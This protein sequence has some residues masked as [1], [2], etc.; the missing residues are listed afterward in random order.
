M[1]IPSYDYDGAIMAVPYSR[2]GDPETVNSSRMMSFT[3]P[4]R[5]A[6][7]FVVVA[8]GLF[9]YL[10][11][12][13]TSLAFDETSPEPTLPF[14]EEEQSFWAFQPI[15]NPDIPMVADETKAANSIDAFLL[16][17]LSKQGLGFSVLANKRQLLRRA[18]FDLLGLP[19]TP[20][21]IDRFVSD[22]SPQ[23]FERMIDRLLAS[24]HYGEKWGRQWLDLVRYAETAGFN[25]DPFRPMAYK[26]RDYVIRAFNNDTPYD[27][28]VQEQIAGDELFPNSTAALI[29]TGFNRMWPDESNASNVE[30][31]RQD[32]LNDL[33][34]N[35]GAAFLGLSIGCAQ[36]HDHK[37]DPILQEDFYQLQSFFAGIVLQD[38]V[39]IGTADELADYQRKLKLWMRQSESVR[40]ELHIIEQTARNQASLIKRLKFPK[41]VLDAI[42]TAPEKR[43]ALQHQ[44]AF[45]SVRQIEVNEKQ[46]ASKLSAEQKKRRAELKQQLAK[47]QKQRPKPPRFLDA[48]ATREVA[49]GP[50]KTHLLD[51]GSYNKPLHE[52]QPGYL[53]IIA[54]VNNLANIVP[55]REGTVGRRTTLAKW[56]TDPRNPLTARVMANRIWQG[57][58]G[59]GLVG[60]ANDLGI[61]TAP[62]RHPELL[63]WLASEFIARDWSIKSMHRLIMTSNAYRQSTFRVP[64]D[65]DLP[66]AAKIDPAN[67]LYWHYQRRRLSAESIRDAMLTIAGKL[68]PKMYGLGVK[69]QLP[70]KFSSREK[71]EVSKQESARNRRS[72][73]IHAKRNLPYPLL[74]VFDFPD[75]HES[76]AKRAQ[77]TVAPQA[78]MILNS[79]LVLKFAEA[80]A[81]RLLRESDSEDLGPLIQ[82]AYVATFSR[83]P[84]EQELTMATEFISQQQQLIATQKKDGKEVKP[85][86]GLPKSADPIKAMAIVDFCHVLLNA[87][88]FLYIE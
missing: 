20:D 51:G 69:P 39:P 71:W 38:R 55:P 44:L 75:M 82:R 46:L 31:A 27:R 66:K 23:A 77:T 41:I 60:N 50:P 76:C 37:F 54:G 58:F 74:K 59:S 43:T 79:D 3:S 80:L 12:K 47:L 88:E 8:V 7:A 4:I 57:H 9:V 36:C 40:D 87:N 86:N 68:N 22:D 70:P 83:M 30:L 52:L 5:V 63:D 15:Q 25:A 32:A 28:F 49:S 72:V 62:P 64:A 13:D 48:M 84:E 42:D 14:T 33:T 18:K 1:L 26:Y 85:I 67:E 34:A 65:G 16:W 17:E 78:L 53:K 6:R 10:T 35:V 21:E 61:Q 29:A 45:W 11:A 81:V 2:Y 56:L 19:P 73:Y 24:P